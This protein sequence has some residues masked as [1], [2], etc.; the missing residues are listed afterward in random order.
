[1]INRIGESNS[2]INPPKVNTENHL[3]SDKEFSIDYKNDDTKT[4]NSQDIGEVKVELST[5]EKTPEEV[6]VRYSLLSEI[7]DKWSEVKQFL[8]K[9][10][11]K[12]WN[13]NTDNG[14]IEYSEKA[15]TEMNLEEVGNYVSENGK[16]K[17]AKNSD[18]L[19]TYNQFGKIVEINPSEKNKIFHGNK[20][21]K[22]L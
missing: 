4:D 6:V 19:T 5:Y 3:K 2:Y 20:S 9:F 17:P 14:E 11:D 12:I 10:W 7:K 18:I 8:K 1:M 22:E 13:G 15:I 16:K 21:W